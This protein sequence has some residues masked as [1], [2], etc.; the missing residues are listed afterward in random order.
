MAVALAG[1]LAL[2]MMAPAA[3]AEERV[4]QGTIGATTVDNLRVPSGAACTLNATK[5]KGTIKVENNATL[6]ANGVRVI[7]NIQSE[8][9]QQIA[10]KEGSRVGGSVQ[11]ENGQ[12]DGIGKVLST[13]INGDL[14]FFS[15]EAKMVARNNTVLGNLQAVQNTGGL[16]IAGN[17]IAENLQCKQNDP[18][19]VG[20]GNKAGDKEDQ[21]AKL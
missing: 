17:T 2:S 7:G 20:G 10:V 9:F 1:V 3:L 6:Y 5:V 13:R 4:C 16:V 18:P 12:G 19:P 8:G 14:Q 15:N 21:C 11:L